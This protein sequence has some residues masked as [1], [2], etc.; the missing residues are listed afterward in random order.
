M[1]TGAGREH[2]ERAQRAP[3]DSIQVTLE[4]AELDYKNKLQVL[5]DKAG[6][7]QLPEHQYTIL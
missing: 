3:S 7:G 5:V 6:L 4:K 2:G 1:R